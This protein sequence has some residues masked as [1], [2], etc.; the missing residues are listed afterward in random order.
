MKV[1]EV[2]SGSVAKMDARGVRVRLARGLY[3]TVRMDHL[4]DKQLQRPLDK[5]RK[6]M[7]VDVLV[8]ESEP[9]RKKLLLSLK[10]PLVSST[11]ARVASYEDATEGTRTHG[12]VA[13]VRP[14]SI[15][16]EMLGGVRGIVRG[17]ELKARFGA[18]WDSDPLSCYREGQVVECTVLTCV[19]AERKLLLTLLSAEEAGAKP[20]AKLLQR[21]A[22]KRKRAEADDDD[23]DEVDDGGVLAASKARA[24]KLKGVDEAVPGAHCL[25][26]A[27]ALGEHGQLLCRLDAKGS[28]LG[29]IHL[30]ELADPGMAAK[31]H[32]ALP[33][34]PLH[35]VVL[36]PRD[37][38]AEGGKAKGAKG[39]SASLEL[40]ARPSER[41]A[42]KKATPSARLAFGDVHEGET[43]HGW[44]RDVTADGVWV[45][46]SFRLTGRVAPLEC[47]DDPAVISKLEKHFKVG[48]PL[49]VRVVSIKAADDHRVKLD[50]S[51]RTGTPAA[52]AAKAGKKSKKA[53]A[54]AVSGSNAVAPA[55][56]AVVP[57]RIV[58]VRA[59]RGVDVQLGGSVY[60]RAHLTELCDEWVQQPL[61]G[62]EPGTYTSCVVLPPLAGHA[63][64]DSDGRPLV[65]VSLRASAV[66]AASKGA[67][68]ASKRLESSSD[69]EG[70]E[71][72]RGYVKAI[73]PRGCFVA[74][75]RTVDAYVGLK[76]ISDDFVNTADLETLV[77]VGTLVV[78]RALPPKDGGSASA[79]PMT[80]RRSD[81]E[82]GTYVSPEV[83]LSFADIEAGMVL[84]GRIK[85]VA[86]FGIFVT[87]DGSKI[88]ALCHSSE[89]SDRKLGSLSVAFKQGEAVK[90]VVLRTNPEKNQVSASMKR[91]RL[92]AVGWDEEA[93]AEEYADALKAAKKLKEAEDE[94]DEEEGEEEDEDE[95]GE[96]GEEEE[97]EEEDDEEM[98]DE[99]GEEMEEEGEE[100]EE[101]EDDD[102]DEEEAG[103]ASAYGGDALGALAAGKGSAGASALNAPLSAGFG[104]GDFQSAQP[105]NGADDAD[106]EPAGMATS[107]SASETTS[108]KS[109][110]IRDR[111]AG[112]EAEA[113]IARREAELADGDDAPGSAEDFERLVIGSPNS[114]YMWMRYMAF[115]L[116]LTEIEKARAVGERALKSI[117]LG[118]HAERFNIHAAML[119]LEKAHGD[120]GTLAKAVSRALMGC[121][122]KQVYTHV[123]SMHERAGD[124]E[125]AD[126]A[127]EICCRKY[128][129][130]PDVW[131]AWI[132]ARMVRGSPAEAKATLQKAL[133]ALITS[134]HADVL[135]KFA[136]LE[137]KHGAAERGRTVFDSL[138]A[139]APKRVDVWSIYIDMEL[140]QGES[141]ATR[142][143]LERVTSLRLSSKKMK[144]FFSRY[145]TYARSEGDDNLIAHVKEKARA[146]VA[147]A[148]ASAEGGGGD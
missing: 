139:N 3:G 53:A 27:V 133:D 98:E 12:V 85:K 13:R 48:Q 106:D 6:G 125:L 51:L 7:A 44:V 17:S 137:F 77:P 66:A 76:H 45:S 62:F 135:S 134:K 121:D 141:D 86:D 127:H 147:S 124:Y 91:S 81:V 92:D 16:I 111:E 145:L 107:A 142:R 29:R 67:T 39:T 71:L 75:S 46:L 38:G 22:S 32:R 131:L 146:W 41:S 30:T 90:V 14:K 148:V 115:Q 21:S 103:G 110:K 2:Y 36:G 120:E 49:A 144:F 10:A 40:S 96:E 87:L 26:T 140:K 101:E 34:E 89:V 9:E 15:L 31:V 80:L 18:L 97:G 83:T 64:K 50:L 52:P 143:L 116:G 95:E 100:E 130:H 122:P 138:L 28:M 74:L 105:S 4:S 93:E 55:E 119:N 117:E 23:D 114:S 88:D 63:A 82:G 132:T 8:T 112:L 72:M 78:G 68:D 102:D 109:K 73:S 60:A 25:A 59:G 108:R 5:F 94:E 58:R 69:V 19:P 104:W 99:E 56:G 47:S 37:D 113:A 43:H 79:L 136:Q 20:A 84:G 42:S 1:G 57:C 118:E 65:D 54:A 35:V 70:G 128:R 11:L 24:K 33:T 61:A 126:G 129:P 123:A